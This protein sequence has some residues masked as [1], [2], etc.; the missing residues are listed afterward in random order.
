MYPVTVYGRNFERP[1][2]MSASRDIGNMP[3][4]MSRDDRR[5]YLDGCEIHLFSR[6]GKRR[7]KIERL[8]TAKDWD[9][10]EEQMA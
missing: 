9:Y 3:P 1:M 6:T 5:E 4:R 10:I 2:P 8:L 7:E